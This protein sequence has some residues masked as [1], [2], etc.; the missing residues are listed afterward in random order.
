MY[1]TML[2]L[3]LIYNLIVGKNKNTLATSNYLLHDKESDLVMVQ[4]RALRPSY[5]VIPPFRTIK[6]AY[7]IT[8]ISKGIKYASFAS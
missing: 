4:F 6:T 5:L 3:L 7:D 1:I 8:S 2:M